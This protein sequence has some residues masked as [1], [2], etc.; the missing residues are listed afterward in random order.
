[1]PTPDVP[2]VLENL[3]RRMARVEQILP[4][5]ATK[6]ELRTSIAEAVAPL[7]TKEELRTSIAAAIAPLATKEEL[8]A[9]V[10]PLAT[11][12]EVWAAIREEGERTRRHVD[13]VAESLRDDIRQIAEGHRALQHR[14]DE[15]DKKIDGLRTDVDRL[16]LR[17]ARLEVEPPPRRSRR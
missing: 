10:A 2:T 4:T 1:M 3:D 12:H 5:L 8:A 9:A 14:A 6:E 7:A 15:H 11:K 16:D 17:V 13:V